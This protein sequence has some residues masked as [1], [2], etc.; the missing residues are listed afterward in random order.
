MLIRTLIKEIATAICALKRPPRISTE[1]LEFWIKRLAKLEKH[2]PSGSGFDDGT[3]IDHAHSSPTKIVL[4]TSF[5]H[6]AESGMYDRWTKHI[7]RIYPSFFGDFDIT[8]S[9]PNY[10]NIKDYIIEVFLNAL[11]AEIEE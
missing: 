7:I 5:H 2:L 6:M 3:T 10:R 4:R 9:G 11:D 8:I 1:T